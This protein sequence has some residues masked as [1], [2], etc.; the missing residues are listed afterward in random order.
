MN[1]LKRWPTRLL[2]GL[3]VA[4]SFL[5]ILEGGARLFPVD[6]WEG[7]NPN[8]SYPLF[9]PG[10]GQFSGQFVTNPH[11][12][13]TMSWQ[14]FPQVKA[15]GT[16]RVFFLGGSAAL[17]WPG[18]IQMAFSSYLHRALGSVSPG[19]FEVINV[20]AMSY[21]SHR[22][23][24]LLADIVGLDPDL[25]VIWSGNNEYVENNAFSSYGRTVEMRWLQRW[26]RH[27]YLYRFIRLRLG[28]VAPDLLSL[29]VGGDITDLR[30]FSQVR[31]GML[32]RSVETDQR[33]LENYREN[34][35]QMASL[36]QQSGAKGVFCTVPVNLSG[37]AP[38]NVA[39]IQTDPATS[40]QWAEAWDRSF[41]LWKQKRYAEAVD[42][43]SHLLGLTT[44]YALAHYLLGDSFLHL[45]RIDEAQAAFD[46]ARDLD[47]RPVRALTSFERAIREIAADEGM[48][49]VDLEGAFAAAS[50]SG[51]PGLDLFLDYVHPNE[52]GHK[53]AAIA[54][55]RDT[56]R[57]LAVPNPVPQLEELIVN[58]DWAKRNSYDQA[59]YFYTLGMTQFNN[60]NFDAAEQAYLRALEIAPDYSEPAGNLAAIYELQGD[61]LKARKFYERALDNDP[62]ALQYAAGLAKVLSRLGDHA[63]AH[64]ISE[65]ILLQGLVDT[66]I[67]ILVGHLEFDEGHF[68]TALEFFRMAVDAGASDPEAQEMINECNRLM[69][70]NTGTGVPEERRSGR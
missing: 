13:R 11:F 2:I 64:K 23:V 38:T 5:L 46:R 51:V 10:E 22:V 54:I 47:I 42:G 28:K 31:R 67:F 61:F 70:N 44:E 4:T 52:I 58:D 15:P 39:P 37:W 53:L 56:A 55:L 43:L 25:I 34:L 68:R 24:D 36:I 3:A 20:A 48:T 41:S 35:R 49:L 66:N 30:K 1:I 21:G 8:L 59:D 19:K 14:S 57:L 63:A 18:P 69:G 50:E 32:G 45:G 7:V 16:Q 33:V 65:Q 29:P 27:S 12:R 62:A 40:R 26:L 17:G 6:S 60:G 9:I